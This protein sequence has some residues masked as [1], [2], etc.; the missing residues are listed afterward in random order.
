M[1]IT[2]LAVLACV[3]VLA[4]SASSGLDSSDTAN[5]LEALELESGGFYNTADGVDALNQNTT[6]TGNSAVGAFALSNNIASSD[7]TAAGT[8]ALAG[9]TTGATN[10]ALGFDALTQNSSGNNN[11]ALG[12]YAGGGLTSTFAN[13][14]GSNNTFIGA[15]ATPGT[16]TQLSDATAIGANA[17]VGESDAL[18]LGASGVQV[19]VG[20][21]TPRSLVQIGSPSTNYGSYLQLPMVTS[22][23]APPAADCNSSTFAGRLVLQYDPNKARTTLWSCSSAGVWTKLAQG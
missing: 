7:N 18:V 13:T 1:A 21:T 8:A 10:S 11:S 16:S 15:N 2:G 20:T 14:T 6:G 4:P 22:T 3:L 23:A 12:E 17:Q 9:N 19:G 5:G